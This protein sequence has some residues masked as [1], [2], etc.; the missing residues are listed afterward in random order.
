MVEDKKMGIG[1]CV[2]LLKDEKVLLGKRHD[3]AEK[4]DSALHGEGTWTLPGGKIDFGE[5]FEQAAF[6]E[7]I[8]ETG[9]KI[10]K[11]K[12]RLISLTNDIVEDAHF[13]TIG[14]LSEDFEG[15]VKV[16]EPDEITEWKWFDLNELPKPMFFPAEK[17]LKNYIDKEV[18]KH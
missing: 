12:L 10:D 2:I 7:S 9:V 5:S 8:E 6:R 4:A 15:D 16:M 1:C 13:V 3:D 18:Y 11:D 14:F 17:A